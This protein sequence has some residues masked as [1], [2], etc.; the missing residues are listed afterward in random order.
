MTI[1]L[2]QFIRSRRYHMKAYQILNEKNI[3]VTRQAM[4]LHT[5]AE[6]LSKAYS[7][8]KEL[9]IFK[10]GIT[11]MIVHDL[12]NPLNSILSTY[13]RLSENQRNKFIFNKARQMLNL[14][15]NIL[16]VYK[17]DAAKMK[18]APA[19]I[20]TNELMVHAIEDI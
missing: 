20:K 13:P 5:Q 8:L 18:I 12:K 15:S 7:E 16:D 6:N 11:A 9:N 19:E 2:I 4:E 17:F 14:I 3:L 1:V 10:D